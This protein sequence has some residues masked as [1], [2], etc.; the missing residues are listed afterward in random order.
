MWADLLHYNTPPSSYG[1]YILFLDNVTGD[2]SE[3][4]EDPSVMSSVTTH[5]RVL[6][7]VIR[8]WFSECLSVQDDCW[9][10]SL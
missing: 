10:Y 2:Y 6:Y 8:C 5:V 1:V 9:F 4:F 7:K 3:D